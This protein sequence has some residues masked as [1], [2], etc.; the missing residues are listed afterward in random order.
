MNSEIFKN[1]ILSTLSEGKVSEAKV[2]LDE[3]IKKAA[4]DHNTQYAQAIFFL[5]T[6]EPDKSIP[7][8]E[9]LS[10]KFPKDLSILSNL[11]NAYLKC[12]E[13]EKAILCLTQAVKIDKKHLSTNYNLACALIKTGKGVQALKILD[14]LTKE[15]NE[16]KYV[17]AK[18][19]A[20]RALGDW[21]KAVQ[22][23]E[24][25]L[26]VDESYAPA[27]LNLTPLMHYLGLL[28]KGLEHG[29]LAIKY[30][31]AN[32]VCYSNLGDILVTL[33]RFEEAM[34]VYADGY[35]VNQNFRPLLASIGKSW[36]IQGEVDEAASWFHKII[37]LDKD[38]L[39]GIA[40]LASV[41]KEKGD[42]EGA[43]NLLEP[44]IDDAKEHIDFLSTLADA[45]WDEGDAESAIKVLYD[46]K[47]L[48]PQRAAI[49]ARIGQ[50]YASSGEMEQ[51]KAAFQ[52]ALEQNPRCV[53][54]INGMAT[55]LRDK[56]NES[57]IQTAN[58]MLK[59][60][61]LSVGQVASLTNALSYY[62]DGLKQPELAA[63]YM[64]RANK[65]HWEKQTQRG[66][67]YNPQEY[68]QLI[69][70]LIRGFD[71]NFFK[72]HYGKVGNTE[73]VPVFIVGMPRSGTT[74]TEQILGRHSQVLGIGERPYVNRSFGVF[75]HSLK[76]H[77]ISLKEGL[78]DISP[79]FI[80][81]INNE[82]LSV[83]DSLVKKSGE[84][85]IVRVV[86]KMPD[87]YSLLGWIVSLFPNAKIIHC[88]RDV[89][90]VALSQWQTQ[91][92][93]IR[94]AN[95]QEHIVERFREYQRIM[96]HWR[97]VLPVKILEIDYEFTT[98]NQEEVSR[99][100]F[101]WIGLDWEEECLK[102]YESD[103]LVR[104]ASISQVRKPIYRT[105]VKKWKQYEP[106]LG[107]LF[108]PLESLGHK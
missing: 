98:S 7:L 93:A 58:D 94:W 103:R 18:G 105:S 51:A 79:D 37:E 57:I 86:D 20:F 1:L 90:D 104:T 29:K 81:E 88:R 39:N 16:A 77:G 10:Q 54:A 106:Y 47:K 78:Y 31:P 71:E 96:Q 61:D 8:L 107:D 24:K 35:E 87:N 64:S 89:C 25:A 100:M 83:L 67:Q 44:H 82:Y 50:V 102:F 2:M 73:I 15:N 19:D 95:H 62:Y 5:V 75:N 9:L 21:R 32:P 66:W 42:S 74:L 99:Q 27:H 12:E 38:D 45:Y 33:E 65:N 36:L 80:D 101:E 26:L 63:E 59:Q 60:S 30:N 28:E 70:D 13:F 49:L 84:T 108:K 85:N 91:F 56:C 92:G 52:D 34:D 11:G 6:A 40:G 23:Y 17:S 22:F 46:L 76:A 69:S 68:H 43:L 41:L 4:H 14:Q 55:N 48:Q 97:E 53:P 72:K 3:L